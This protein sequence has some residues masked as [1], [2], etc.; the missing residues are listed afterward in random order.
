MKSFW[1]RRLW[2]VI[3]GI[4]FVGLFAAR[5]ISSGGL[6]GI[7]IGFH[8]LGD[9]F[10]AAQIDLEHKG[11]QCG[12]LQRSPNQP[13][14][15][16]LACDRINAPL[17]PPQDRVYRVEMA[18][19]GDKITH[20]T[21][22]VCGSPSRPC[23]TSL[24]AITSA[25]NNQVAPMTIP[26]AGQP[27]PPSVTTAFAIFSLIV[28]AAWFLDWRHYIR[29]WLGRNPNYQGRWALGFR[30]FFAVS[31]ISSLQMAVRSISSHS[32]TFQDCKYAAFWLLVM[33]AA[34]ATL[35]GIFRLSMGRPKV[36]TSEIP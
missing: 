34:G 30:I 25:A 17:S 2:I 15:E 21:T 36:V 14:V 16:A 29:F 5:L 3:F 1:G 4:V 23:P 7:G 12:D 9:S 35:D 33:I 6:G 8:L 28:T 32:W 20:V 24:A 10:A 18:G 11:F 26:P 22:R 31:F 13:S 19:S 27:A